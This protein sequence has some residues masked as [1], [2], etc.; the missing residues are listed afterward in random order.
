MNLTIFFANRNIH[1]M[2]NFIAIGL[3]FQD[4]QQKFVV[5][6]GGHVSEVNDHFVWMFILLDLNLKRLG[7]SLF[8]D[9][10]FPEANVP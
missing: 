1:I 3:G 8:P 7:V 6:V 5:R 4:F 2:P 9:H 10:F